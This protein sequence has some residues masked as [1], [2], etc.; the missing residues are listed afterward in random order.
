[1]MIPRFLL[2]YTLVSLPSTFII[3]VRFNST[4]KHIIEGFFLCTYGKTLISSSVISMDD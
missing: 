1:M 3:I 2:K 4:V